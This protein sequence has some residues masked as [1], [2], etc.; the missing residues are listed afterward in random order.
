MPPARAVTCS[1]VVA[2]LALGCS[3]SSGPASPVD[4]GV[5]VADASSDAGLVVRDQRYCEILL[6]T[7]GSGT[8]H[9]DV[10][11]TF[12]LNDCPEAQW[13]QVDAATVA[14][15]QGVSRAILNGP[16][17]WLMDAFVVGA[18]LDPTP[19]EVGG[20]M[21]RHAGSIDLPTS[22]ATT[23]QAPYVQ[24][25]IQRQTTVLFA[26]GKPVYELLDPAGKIYEM[27]SWSVQKTPQTE[28]DLATLGGRLSLPA[29][30]SYRTRTLAQDL[31]VTAVNDLATVVQDDFANTYQQSQQ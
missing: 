17:Y 1:I 4:A 31:T 15:Q 22:Q 21:M 13:A 30:W 19:K 5:D 24:H 14:Q 25:Q 8:I 11:N 18:F 16:R 12:G 23:M 3:A 7:I 9:V 26:A 28:A 2:L 6:A 20:L 10:Y 29:G 27:Q